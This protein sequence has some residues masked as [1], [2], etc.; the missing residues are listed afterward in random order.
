MDNVTHF[1]ITA[2]TTG[3]E[4]ELVRKQDKKTAF[5]TPE[6]Q[7]PITIDGKACEY[8]CVSGFLRSF[9]PVDHPLLER[10]AVEVGVRKY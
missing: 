9:V 5:M 4:S 8:C 2:D 7:Q 1:Y 6:H 3:T 10:C